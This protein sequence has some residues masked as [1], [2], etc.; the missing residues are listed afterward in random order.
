MHSITSTAIRWLERYAKE[1]Q[2]ND[3]TLMLADVNPSVMEVLEA[4]GALDVIGDDNVFPATARVLEA[5]KMSW[6]AAQ[7]I[8]SQGE[9]KE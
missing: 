3:S 1:L 6:E 9:N 8:I 7:A 2:A 5:E 4:S